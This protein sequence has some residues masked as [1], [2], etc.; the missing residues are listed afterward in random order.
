MDETSDVISTEQLG[1][2]ATFL[3]NQSISK[4]FIGPISISKDVGAHLSEVNI[5]SALENFVVKNEMNLQEA[6][7]VCMNT[8]NIN[9]GEKNGLKRRLE[10]KV[11]LLEW[12]GCN[13]HK[14]ALTFKHL[15]PSFQCLVE[16]DI[17][18]LNHRKYFK[19]RPLAVNI[20]GNTIEMYGD[21]PTVPTCLSDTQ[22][23]TIV[24]PLQQ[25]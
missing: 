24:K 11:P 5:I 19:Y 1:I 7:F 12:I 4:H 2:Y 20:L 13:N 10:H 3:K 22:W 15:I 25:I 16:L 14:L 6:R 18:L 9:S 23:Q 21:S 17:F 8:T